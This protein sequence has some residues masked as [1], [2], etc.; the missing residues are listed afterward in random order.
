[1]LAV[2]TGSLKLTRAGYLDGELLVTATGIE[3]ILPA[4][5]VDMLA[6][7]G[8]SRNE[9]IGAALNFLDKMAPGAIAGAVSLLGDPAELEGR[10][11]TKMPLRF[12]DGVATLGPVKLGQTAPLF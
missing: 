1:L 3:K 5:G 9:R 8:G 6:R 10:R 12:K 2:A 7:Q 11:A 4:L